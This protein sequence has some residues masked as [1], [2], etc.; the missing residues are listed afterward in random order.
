MKVDIAVLNKAR[1]VCFSFRT[2]ICFRANLATQQT[3]FRRQHCC[4]NCFLRGK[5]NYFKVSQNE[6]FSMSKMW[7]EPYCKTF[8]FYHLSSG[9]I[10]KRNQHAEILTVHLTFWRRTFFSNFSTPVFK[11]WVIQKPNKVALWN[12]RHFE[13]E[14][15]EIIQHV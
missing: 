12:K 2:F 13:G 10:S 1:A 7:N 8:A 4:P 6:K 5:L 15:M 9:K 11:M 3:D 14:K